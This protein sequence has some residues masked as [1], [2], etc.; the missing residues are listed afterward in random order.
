MRAF[1][2]SLLRIQEMLSKEGGLEYLEALLRYEERVAQLRKV[3][4]EKYYHYVDPI[5]PI[6][7]Q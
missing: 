7:P 1:Y 6:P 3:F 2:H 4:R 5:S